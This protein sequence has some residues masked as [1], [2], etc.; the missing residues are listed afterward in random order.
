MTTNSL[1][2]QHDVRRWLPLLFCA[3]LLVPVPATA[4]DPA[5]VE[6]AARHF[7]PNRQIPLQYGSLDLHREMTDLDWRQLRVLKDVPKLKHISFSASSLTD[8]DLIHLKDFVWLESFS[9]YDRNEIARPRVH[10]PGLTHLSRLPRLRSLG[11]ISD[12]FGEEIAATLKEFP[13]LTR[14]YVSN[15]HVPES[16]LSV[17][18]DIYDLEELHLGLAITDDGLQRLKPLQKLRVL[19]I[20]FPS[21]M[22]TGPQDL[23]RSRV[24]WRKNITDTALEH[25][26]ALRNLRTLHVGSEALST[27]GPLAKLPLL[28][29]LDLYGVTG[30]GLAALAEFPALRRL[31]LRG[32]CDEASLR[33]ISRSAQLETLYCMGKTADD[34]LFHLAELPRL[35]QLGLGSSGVTDAGI[36]DLRHVRSLERLELGFTEL[37]DEGMAALAE[38]PRL[39]ILDAQRTRITNG[40]VPSLEKMAALQSFNP[41]ETGFSTDAYTALRQRRPELNIAVDAPP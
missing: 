2:S 24:A 36:I 22:I 35:K 3:A 19:T 21:V 8:D 40:C 18:G 10:G 16:I 39:K 13:H 25:L 12:G 6:T 30:D 38:L 27:V 31:Y 4:A 14:L 17:I 32:T 34:G 26:A 28:E 20:R 37:G 15:A 9:I 1:P 33:H 5:H 23:K 7:E 11:L 41:I 29:E